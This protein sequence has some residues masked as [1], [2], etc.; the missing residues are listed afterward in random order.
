MNHTKIDRRVHRSRRLLREAFLSLVLE[1]GYDVVTV[2]D[3][4]ERADLGRTTF[5][6]HYRDK[7]E[8]L[9]ECLDQVASELIQEVQERG[10]WDKLRNP[11]V[12]AAGLPIQA[13]LVTVFE[14]AKQKADLYRIILRGE[15][16]YKAQIR[17]HQIITANIL[18][19]IK[20]R[21][22]AVGAH[23]Q[24]QVPLEVIATFYASALLGLINWWLEIP[25][26]YTPAEMGDMFRNLYFKG[27]RQVMG[28]TGPL[29]SS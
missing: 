9:L 11:E 14:M 2:E 7:D 27:A 13:P 28:L 3:I 24:P 23:A 22:A 19:L 10:L 21:I 16:G 20:E 1:K 5:Y 18:A 4:T 17:L 15:G 8:L 12:D 6:L 29:P 26:S 25:N